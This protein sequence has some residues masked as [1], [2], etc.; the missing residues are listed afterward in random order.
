M[1]CTRGGKGNKF[2]GRV[3]KLARWRAEIQNEGK[4]IA[5]EASSV[6]KLI[7]EGFA[8]IPLNPVEWIVCGGVASVAGG[9]WSGIEIF[10]N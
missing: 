10:K 8:A 6:S 1:R 4:T 2:R 3:S 5:G 7:D 9:E